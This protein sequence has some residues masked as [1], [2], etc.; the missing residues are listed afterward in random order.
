MESKELEVFIS[1]M[2]KLKG[3]DFSSYRKNFLMRRINYRINT[4]KSGN[5]FNYL[6]LLK[7]DNAEYN[8]FLDNLAIN[9]SEFFRDP[10][11]FEYFRE[12]C[13]KEIISR[14]G[15]FNNRFIRV[16]SAG[17]AEGQE[18]Y[19][20]A[21][22]FR[23]E[24]GEESS[25]SVKI[26]GTDIDREALEKAKRA[27]YEAKNLKN[28]DRFMVEKYF[29]ALPNDFLRLNENVKQM[30]QF[31][32]LDLINDS[33]LKYMDVIFCR[34]VMIYL[35][36]QQQELLFLKF[37]DSLSSKGYLVVGKVE[38]FWGDTREI[39]TSVAIHKKIFQRKEA[40]T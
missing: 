17:C 10:D 26:W 4:T 31:N 29:T 18:T 5:L 34:N 38:S 39:F 1:T 16:W 19:S 25:L 35:S 40:K 24:L 27:E 21:I 37:R 32:R 6:N 14:K 9:V 15:S 13:L 2:Q 20:L 3:V 8:R 23:E 30:V 11:V 28:L 33:P 7:K 22:L 36:H 12:N